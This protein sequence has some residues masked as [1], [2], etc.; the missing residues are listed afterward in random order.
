MSASSAACSAAR[1][2]CRPN[3][4]RAAASTRRS[5]KL[6]IVGAAIG[7]AAYGLRPCVE[8][9]F[10][11]YMYPAY[12][13]IVSEA[14]RLRYRSN[15][16]FHLPDRGAHADRRRHLRRPDAQPEPRGA[17]HPRVRAEDGGAV[18]SVRR[19]GL[20][21]RGDRGS[22][23]GDLPRA[24]AALQRP[25]RRPSRPADHAVVQARAG[26]GSGRP[27]RDPARQGGDPACRVGA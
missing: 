14:A 10:A 27:L 16:R 26:R 6:G 24:E 8:I 13:Q 17:V 19:Q 18:Q 9:Q 23:S 2:A 1:R 25:V 12:D 5:T 4:A 11:D 20:A 7:M 3:T 22:R 15:G 21:D